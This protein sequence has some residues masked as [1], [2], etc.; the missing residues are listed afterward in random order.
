MKRFA[1]TSA[2]IFS[3]LAL[4][5]C[6]SSK[7]SKEDAAGCKE[8]AANATQT[9]NDIS[10]WM[11]QQPS[12]EGTR[13]GFDAALEIGNTMIETSEKAKEL[14]SKASSK[15]TKKIFDAIEASFKKAAIAIASRGGSFES[16]EMDLLK[17]AVGTAEDMSKFCGI[18]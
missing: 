3:V 18:E 11:N 4:S 5:A 13:A 8:L 9:I 2:V 16:G 7:V 15:A 14:S 10:S 17:K 1:I 12:T 6:G